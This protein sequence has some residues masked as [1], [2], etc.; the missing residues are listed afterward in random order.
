LRGTNERWAAELR[1]QVLLRSWLSPE[2]RRQYD[3]RG[4]FEVIGGDTGRRYLICKGEVFNIQELDD[5]GNEICALCVTAASVA[6]GDINL[7]QKI[8]LETFENKVL[9][10]A[11]RTRGRFGRQS[12]P[13]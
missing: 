3:E 6:T 1:A 7:A 2:Q 12:D 13:R 11:N 8:A 4:S 9:A 10:I 5:R